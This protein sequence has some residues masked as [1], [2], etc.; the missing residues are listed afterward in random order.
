[1]SEA[2]RLSALA[3]FTV[4]PMVALLALL[5]R[6][7][8]PSPT[9]SRISGWRWYVPMVLLPV[10]WLLAPAL[11]ALRAGE[12]EAGWQPVRAV[13]FAVGLA[14]AVLLVWASAL[15]GRFMI[16]EAAIRVGHALIESGPYRFVRHPVYAGY[17]ALLF[18]SGLA[19]LNFCLWLLWPVS[20]LGILVQA[21]SE[22]QLLR[23]RFGQGYERYA[24][25]T[26]RLVP[27]F[28]GQAAV[29]RTGLLP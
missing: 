19:S 11:I 17:L 28:G 7:L 13:G 21:A 24:R 23:E 4:G 26:G 27:R 22:E 8:Q 2:L 25:R 1:M 6:G 16:H 18:G 29:S 15:L 14:G 3:L 20:L 12:I 5:R 10:E 9:L